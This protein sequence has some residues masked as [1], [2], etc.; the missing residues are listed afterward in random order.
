MATASTFKGV[1]RGSTIELER[2]PGLP[3]GQAVSVEIRPI[4]AEGSGAESPQ[5]P[6]WLEHLDVDPSVRPGKFVVKGT[7]LL[8][9]TLVEQLEAG[10]TEQELLQAHAELTPNDLAAVCQY[11]KLPVEMRRSFGAWADEAEQL[12]KYLQWTRQQ[13]KV[14]RGR[15]E[16]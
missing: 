16:R 9:D 14:T 4:T 6:W 13:R 11:A 12:D 2:E 3:D 8:A 10:Q 5:P 7:H 15:I 1:V